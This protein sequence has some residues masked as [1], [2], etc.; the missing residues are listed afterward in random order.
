[1]TISFLS[2]TSYVDDDGQIHTIKNLTRLF[3]K[4]RYTGNNVVFLWYPALYH[5][6]IACTLLQMGASKFMEDIM[7]SMYKGLP[8][9]DHFE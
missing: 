6:A 2:L 1:M 9:P 7:L 5:A 4:D 8:F 3:M